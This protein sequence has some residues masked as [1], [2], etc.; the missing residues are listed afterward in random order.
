MRKLTILL[1]LLLF[2]VLTIGQTNRFYQGIKSCVYTDFAFAPAYAATFTLTS[3]YNPATGLYENTPEYE[4]RA[5]SS[6]SYY[7]LIYNL[8]FNPV[9]FGEDMGIGINIA[10]AFAFS[11]SEDGIGNI[12]FPG[13]LT[14]N[15][16]AG[17][18][19]ETAKNFG[20]YLGAGLEYNQLFVIKYD[21]NF[22]LEDP[23]EKPITTWTQPMVIAGIRWWSKNNVLKELSFKYGFGSNPKEASGSNVIS[24]KTFQ[25][26]FGRFLNY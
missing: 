14:L 21:D 26:S 24:P 25:L 19:Y 10:P 16:G 6:F 17:S 2:T 23:V 7:T 9:E 15:F 5:L 13:Y 11:A 3:E 20:Y 8:R 1:A 4:Y 12:N 18:T 22:G